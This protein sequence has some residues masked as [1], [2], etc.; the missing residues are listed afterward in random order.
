[1]HE[2]TALFLPGTG[3]LVA[4]ITLPLPYYIHIGCAVPD[5]RHKAVV[6]LAA[7]SLHAHVP[8]ACMLCPHLLSLCVVEQESIHGRPLKI[9]G[10]HQAGGALLIGR[11][12]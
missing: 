7:S 1:M 8:A 10:N 6:L 4:F 2:R 3:R 9:H 11:E 5:R 12:H